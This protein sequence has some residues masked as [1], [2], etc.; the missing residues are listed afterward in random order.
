MLLYS[1]NKNK[2]RNY[3]IKQGASLVSIDGYHIP[4]DLIVGCSITTVL[5]H[6]RIFIK[7]ISYINSILLITIASIGDNGDTVLGVF[8]GPVK[9]DYTSLTLERMSKYLSGSLMIGSYESASR[10]PR[11]LTF[12]RSATELEESVIFCY[13]P[14]AVKK[15]KD[16]RGEEAA[17]F[18]KFGKLISIAKTLDSTTRK[19]RFASLYPATLNNK[20]D[21]SSFLG[22]CA[23]PA[24]KTINGVSPAA[25]DGNSVNDGNIYIAGVKPVVFYGITNPLT[26]TTDSGV[27]GIETVDVSLDSLCTQKQKLLPPIV[28]DSFT[29]DSDEFKNK[30]Y[31]KPAMGPR[32]AGDDGISFARPAR[33][34]G[35][36]NSANAPE[37]LF[38]PQFTKL[39]NYLNYKYWPTP[40]E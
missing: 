5:E 15:I 22:N 2:Y 3:P 37:Y 1:E 6:S 12:D 11:V 38:W 27:I 40:E 13:S 17:G 32:D 20:S 21:K 24:I 7:Q 18:V 19:I 31:N 36:F 33:L 34:A 9:K 29:I 39:D 10:I 8:K 23:T 25:V 16:A 4:Q 35:N 28:I 30:Y 26:E 14:P